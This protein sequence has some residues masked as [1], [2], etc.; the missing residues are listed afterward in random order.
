MQDFFHFESLVLNRQLK[1]QLTST[2]Y[3]NEITNRIKLNL[4]RI[5]KKILPINF[6]HQIK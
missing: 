6:F 5:N 2:E 3:Q 4:A 1:K